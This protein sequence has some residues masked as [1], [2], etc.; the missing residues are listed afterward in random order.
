MVKRTKPLRVNRDFHSFV[1]RMQ[2][3]LHPIIGRRPS[4]SEVT[5]GIFNF[6]KLEGSD[7]RMVKRM[8]FFEA[9]RR[10][11]KIPRGLF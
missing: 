11:G 1:C 10:Q 5:Q 7:K 4:S 6:I 9:Q 3:D 2:K 8:Q